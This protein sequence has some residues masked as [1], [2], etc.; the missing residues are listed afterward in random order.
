MYMVQK[1]ETKPTQQFV[2]IDEVRDGVLFLKNGPPRSKG[3][4]PILSNKGV[5]RPAGYASKAV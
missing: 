5:S 4:R 3:C 2:E 1:S